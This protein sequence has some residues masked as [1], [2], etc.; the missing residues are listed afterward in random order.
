MAN[1]KMPEQIERMRNAGRL[2]ASVLEHLI[3]LAKPGVTTLEL[4]LEAE[5]FII[6]ELKARPATKGQYGFPHAMTTAINQVVCH[7][8]PRAEDL[9]QDGDI[10]NLDVTVEKDG[11][12]CDTSRMFLIGQIAP[13]AKRL[14]DVTQECLWRAMAEIKPG[15][16]LGDI[17]HA[18]ESHA[19]RA[20]FSV[21]TEY[22]GHGIGREMH[23]APQ[24]L[25]Y[26]KPG[27]GL[28]LKPGMTF[29][30]E[31][32]INAGKAGTKE[33]KDGWTVVTRD[34]SLSAQWEHTVLVTET[35]VEVLTL[36]EEERELVQRYLGA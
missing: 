7:G 23:E 25:H 9:L 28:K 19:S 8:I 21:V 12:I 13:E 5:R 14:V 22:C 1:I 32:M 10:V 24:V 20:G 29:T 34:G 2:A 3:P 30:I 11:Y 26:G 35:G 4:S 15:A 16:R 31:P 33:L 17:G 18:I 36:R 6:E 27:R